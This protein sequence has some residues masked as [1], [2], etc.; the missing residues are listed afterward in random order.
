MK[1]SEKIERAKAHY[2]RGWG[3]F[4]TDKWKKKVILK[5][6]ICELLRMGIYDKKTLIEI[7]E[8]VRKLAFDGDTSMFPKN[9]EEKIKGFLTKEDMR[10]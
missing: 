6:E 10:V 8:Y 4:K 5:L 2:L 9:E 7:L 3:N 1:K